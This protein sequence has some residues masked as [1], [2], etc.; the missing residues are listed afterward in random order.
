MKTL[1]GQVFFIEL[2]RACIN[3]RDNY[4]KKR[5]ITTNSVMVLLPKTFCL[6]ILQN[7]FRLFLHDITCSRG[8]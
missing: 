1:Q 7:Q 2:I 3:Q 4:N 5:G 6:T 8:P